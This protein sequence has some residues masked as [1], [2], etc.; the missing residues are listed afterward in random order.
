MDKIIIKYYVYLYNKHIYDE[1]IY[2]YLEHMYALDNLII[3]LYDA[4][5]YL[6]KISI[7]ENITFGYDYIKI[8]KIRY[9]KYDYR[10]DIFIFYETFITYQI[11]YQDMKGWCNYTSKNI[12]NLLKY[13]NDNVYL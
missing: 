3:N 8:H 9:S 6:Y 4:V 5:N 13:I 10:C 7:K 1:Y 11:G 2:Y 12:N